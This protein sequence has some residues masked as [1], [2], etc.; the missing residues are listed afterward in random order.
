MPRSRYPFRSEPILLP[1]GSTVLRRFGRLRPNLVLVALLC[2]TVTSVERARAEEPVSAPIPASAAVPAPL[3]TAAE[4]P[5]LDTGSSQAEPPPASL[6]GRWWFW[7]AVGLVAAATVGVVLL[8][9]RG[10]AVPATDL[11]NQE[12]GR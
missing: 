1:S 11:G 8:S 5:G 2:F 6:F 7:T 10:P 4:A 9:S 12:L 3:G